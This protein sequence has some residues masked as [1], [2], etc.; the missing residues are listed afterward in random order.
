[1][2]YVMSYKRKLSRSISIPNR[3]GSLAP[4]GTLS[5]SQPLALDGLSRFAGSSAGR[6][7]DVSIALIILL[8]TLPILAILCLAIWAHDRGSPIF[9]HRRIGRGG[10]AF[11]CLK[12]RTMVV[13]SDRR[14]R[15]LLES[16]PAAAFEWHVSQKLRNDPRITPLGAFLRKSSLDELPQLVNVL[17]GHMSLVGPRPIVEAEVGRY[18]RY[19]K[20]YCAVRPGITGLWQVSGRNDV[21]YRRRVALDTVYARS[22]SLFMDLSILTRT[23]PAVLSSKGCS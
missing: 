2:G 11:P 19:F 17:L 7:L 3:F 13:D 15:E 1:M 6:A 20:F 12:L 5:P 23:V 4:A 22:H 16:D 21:S 18:G 10:Q 14:L 9:A 8:V